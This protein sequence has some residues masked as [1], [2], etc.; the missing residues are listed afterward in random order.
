MRYLCPLLL[1]IPFAIN[2]AQAD[3]LANVDNAKQNDELVGEDLQFERHQFSVERFRGHV[4]LNGQL[5]DHAVSAGSQFVDLIETFD[6]L[7]FETDHE[8]R[9]WVRRLRGTRT[10]TY[11]NVIRTDEQGQVDVTPLVLLPAETRTKVDPLWNNWLLEQERAS[12]RAQSEHE[13]DHDTTE[14]LVSLLASRAAAPVA[15]ADRW[16]VELVP[17]GSQRLFLTG[18][19]QATNVFLN[20]RSVPITFGLAGTPYDPTA[21]R[22]KYVRVSAYDSYEASV[23]ATSQYPGYES[24]TIRKLTR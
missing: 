14:L 22:A 6:H 10:Y 12:S 7:N 16:E 19:E 17:R 2:S 4:Y 21:Y 15:T 20:H 3:D 9:N 18:P 23:Q 5:G 11:D 24:R 8:F 1:L 13:S